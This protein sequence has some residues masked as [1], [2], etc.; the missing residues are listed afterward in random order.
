MFSSLVIKIF[1]FYP[2]CTIW[3]VETRPNLWKSFNEFQH[4]LFA[5]FPF[6]SFSFDSTL[7]ILIV[8]FNLKVF[9]FQQIIDSASENLG[10]HVLLC[11]D[12]C[13]PSG[14]DRRCTSVL[15]FVLDFI[16]YLPWSKLIF[17]FAIGIFISTLSKNSPRI[18]WLKKSHLN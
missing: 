17:G 2:K 4:F 13:A 12:I 18:P 14:W 6:I 5:L 15:I 10:W 8:V 7:L 11:E 3:C 9:I 1:L 16:H